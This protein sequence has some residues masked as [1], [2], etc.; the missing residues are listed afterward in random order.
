M[1]D[2]ECSKKETSHLILLLHIRFDFTLLIACLLMSRA[3][4]LGGRGGKGDE[5]ECK[6]CD[7]KE[8]WEV[9]RG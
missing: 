9:V 3:V 8:R 2:G 6:S 1:G 5:L 4:V 7:T